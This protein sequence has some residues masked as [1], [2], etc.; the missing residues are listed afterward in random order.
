MCRI[1]KGQSA[2]GQADVR[3]AAGKEAI[4]KELGVK[5]AK[6]LV[7]ATVSGLFGQYEHSIDFQES[8]NF[9]I[10]YGPNGVGK[11]KFIE[12]VYA[13]QSLN[14]FLLQSMP[15]LTAELIY[16][17]DTCLVVTRNELNADS[18]GLRE[19][20]AELEFQ[21][22][23]YSG[24]SVKWVPFP[25]DFYE[26]LSQNPYFVHLGNGEWEDVRRRERY[27]EDEL[28]RRFKRVRRPL[29]R[30]EQEFDDYSDNV[31]YPAAFKEF[32]EQVSSYFIDSQRLLSEHY[33][34]ARVDSSAEVVRG[35]RMTL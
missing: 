1:C 24:N 15:F 19:T 25:P 22:S 2:D 7:K 3:D 12:I 16:S 35:K 30:S 18:S 8:D 11:T 5:S 29:R 6:K 31:E 4:A 26:Y 20:A 13:A 33:Y 27:K 17:D 14:H 10:I 28:Y 21:L 23:D 34:A 9:V 32:S